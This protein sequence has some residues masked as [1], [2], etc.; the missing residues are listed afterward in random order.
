[1]ID[2]MVE[3]MKGKWWFVGFGTIAFVILGFGLPSAEAAD[4]KPNILVIFG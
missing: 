2:V 4:K 3:I 1:M